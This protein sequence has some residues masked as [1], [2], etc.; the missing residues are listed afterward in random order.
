M[1][2]ERI[3]SMRRLASICSLAIALLYGCDEPQDLIKNALIDRWCGQRPCNWEVKGEIARVGTWNA[4]DYAVRFVSD[5]AQISQL[6]ASVQAGQDDPDG[7]YYEDG[8]SCYKFTMLAKIEHG[9]K[10]YLE[11]DFLDDGVIDV[12]Q[13]IAESDWDYHQFT[14]KPP[15]WYHGVRFILRKD[16]SGYAALAQLSAETSPDCS[17]VPVDL[18]GRPAGAPC[19]DDEQCTIGSCSGTGYCG[20]CERDADCGGD[21]ICVALSESDDP[22]L[23]C[24]PPASIPF[25]N[26]CTRDEACATGVCCS[27]ICSTCCDTTSDVACQGDATCDYA[28]IDPAGGPQ[29]S[30]SEWPKVCAPGNHQGKSGDTCT[31]DTDCQS[32]RCTEKPECIFDCDIN[33]DF[34]PLCGTF[35]GPEVVRGGTC[36]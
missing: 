13:R 7:G 32:D 11:L 10:L 35:F 4:H 31:S 9:A 8:A 21:D 28:V 26:E 30:H 17:G 12:S 27:G 14:V 24:I 15:T 29:P 22:Q 23:S 3:M 36:E 6:N 16:S 18:G 33:S 5:H 20:G 25:G 19:E 1:K 34:C 2:R